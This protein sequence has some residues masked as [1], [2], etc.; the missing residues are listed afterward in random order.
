MDAQGCLDKDYG[1]QFARLVLRGGGK[2]AGGRCRRTCS[3]FLNAVHA[4]PR[5]DEAV[6]A[7]GLD[8][9]ESRAGHPAVY[10]SH[11]YGGRLD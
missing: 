11:I 3:H 6:T 4:V 2:E 7:L 9:S 1:V 8:G 5:K 10:P